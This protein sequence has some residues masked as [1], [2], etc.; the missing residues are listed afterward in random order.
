MSPYSIPGIELPA[1]KTFDELFDE[2]ISE[3][4]GVPVERIK[5]EDRR[6]KRTEVEARQFAMW[7]QK[8]NTKMSLAAIG[9]MYGGRRHD[10]VLW[11]IKTVNNLMETDKVFK[12][13]AEDALTKI[14]QI[15]M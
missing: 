13:K 4:F 14:E 9:K 8:S 2:A 1:P 10:T 6:R 5:A 15:K 12:E 7:W 11:A 3:A